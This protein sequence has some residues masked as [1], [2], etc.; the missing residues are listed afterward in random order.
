MVVLLT[1]PT[2]RTLAPFVTARAVAP[3]IFVADVSSTVTSTPVAVDMVK[4]DVDVVSMMPVEPPAAGPDRAPVEVGVGT[5]ED[6]AVAEGDDADGE[7]VAAAATPELSPTIA[8]VSPAH[9]IHP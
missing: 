5:G 9:P 7:K 1:V 4:P 6:V 3:W 2:T 8:N